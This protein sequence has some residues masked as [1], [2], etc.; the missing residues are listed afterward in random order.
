MKFNE[1]S[2]KNRLQILVVQET[3]DCLVKT[4]FKHVVRINYIVKVNDICER[5]D[6]TDFKVFEMSWG[7]SVKLYQ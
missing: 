3:T 4:I 6:S 5:N 1:T 7:Q 2:L